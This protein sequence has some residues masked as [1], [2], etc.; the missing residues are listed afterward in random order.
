M[1]IEQHDEE[2]DRSK[3]ELIVL[4]HRLSALKQKTTTLHL[5]AKN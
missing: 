3:K 5:L 2:I 1:L 4:E